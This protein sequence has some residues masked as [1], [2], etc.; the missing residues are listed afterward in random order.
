[1]FG[2]LTADQSEFAK[3]FCLISFYIK[4]AVGNPS[5]PGLMKIIK[6]LLLSMR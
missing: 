2:K 1:L 5:F 3:H 6:I 4:L